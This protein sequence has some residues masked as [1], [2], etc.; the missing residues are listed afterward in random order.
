MVAPLWPREQEAGGASLFSDAA[1]APGPQG[2]K[3]SPSSRASPL[4]DD[5]DVGDSASASGFVGLSRW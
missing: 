1:A 3:S 4:P 5:A 2:S